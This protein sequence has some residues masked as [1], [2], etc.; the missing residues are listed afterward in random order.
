MN[1]SLIKRHII[2]WAIA[3]AGIGLDQLAKYLVQTHIELNSV[4]KIWWIFGISHI[5]NTGAAWGIFKNSTT[6][7]AIFS[8]VAAIAIGVFFLVFSHKI[9]FMR[10]TAFTIAFSLI[11]SGTVGNLIDR[12]FVGYVTDFIQ[13]GSFP[14][15]NIADSCI[16]CGSILLAILLI[17]FSKEESSDQEEND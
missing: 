2:F 5:H 13:V 3:L 15:F 4:I 17:F 6:L 12:A 7:L 11:F 10:P 9:K 14:N 16:V 1:K 8:T